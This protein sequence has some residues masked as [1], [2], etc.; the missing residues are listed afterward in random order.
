MI[1]Q[2]LLSNFK[3]YRYGEAYPV[4]TQ[5]VRIVGQELKSGNKRIAG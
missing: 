2:L 3:G 5:V 4:N 1:Y